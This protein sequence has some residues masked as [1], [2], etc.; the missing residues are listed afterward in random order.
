M[1]EII[2]TEKFKELVG[3]GQGKGFTPKQVLLSLKDKGY[4]VEGYNANYSPI[5]KTRKT[6]EF[7]STEMVK[8]IP[9][10]AWEMGKNIWTAATNPLQTTN[11]MRSLSV[12]AMGKLL[13]SIGYKSPR[14]ETSDN[15]QNEEIVNSMIDFMVE[16]YGSK[17][18]LLN[19][20]EKDPVGFSAD[21]ASVMGGAGVAGKLALPGKLGVAAGKV[22]KYSR[23]L[24]PDV[25]AIKSSAAFIQG[26]GL[27]KR[28]FHSVANRYM[29]KAS[30]LSETVRRD[31]KNT[32]GAKPEEWLAKHGVSGTLEDMQK[33]LT[34]ING[35]T[36]NIVDDLLA[37]TKGIYK[38]RSADKF[39]V[40]LR[41]VFGKE[42]VDVVTGADELKILDKSGKP[43]IKEIPYKQ[44]E[45]LFIPMENM[46]QSFMD[47]VKEIQGFLQKNRTEGLTLT[48]LNKVKRVGDQVFD[49]FD[50]AGDVKSQTKAQNLGNLRVEIKEFIEKAANKEG[51]PDIRDLNKQTQAS[52]LINKEIGKIIDVTDTRS[53]M[54]DQ[55]I[56]LMGLTGTAAGLNFAP[57]AGAAL[58][59]GGRHLLRRPQVRSFVATRL[60]LMSDGDFQKLLKGVETGKKQSIMHI[61]NREK[62]LLFKTFPELRLAGIASKKAQENRGQQTV[63]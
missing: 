20:I 6:P 46:S 7:S 52:G 34:N 36:K 45:Q 5:E 57:F 49:I 14:G 42:G 17:D 23:Y 39:L 13:K 30:G 8:N 24:Q 35:A 33:Q 2:T 26:T 29:A 10:S 3:R 58:I 4:L 47:D 18:K 44:K 55:L 41:K 11:A 22:A 62:Q 15:L 9:E 54:G 12:G 48:E 28:I 32:L 40:E 43:I 16:R 53:A 63:E 1:P 38:S 59:V 50:K 27:G 60:R 61:I 56:F 51:I 37:S 19:T 21:L 25:A 31:I